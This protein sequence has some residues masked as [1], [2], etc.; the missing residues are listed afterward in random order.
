MAIV[1]DLVLDLF[2]WKPKQLI[3]ADALIKE[4]KQ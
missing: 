3:D 4:V 1:C 2:R